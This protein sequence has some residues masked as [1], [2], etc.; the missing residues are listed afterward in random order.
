MDDLAG[1]TVQ[2]EEPGLVSA[3]G[4]RLGDEFVR[5]LKVELGC[6]HV[7]NIFKIGGR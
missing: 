2:N 1:V 3:R 7:V 5:E 4:R 6:E